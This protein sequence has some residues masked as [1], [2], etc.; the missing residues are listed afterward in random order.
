MFSIV[1]AAMGA[2]INGF[3]LKRA[4]ATDVLDAITSVL[5]WATAT[6]SNLVWDKSPEDVRTMNE[7]K[8]AAMGVG[9]DT[10]RA[11]V[12]NRWLTPTVSVPFAEHL[13]RTFSNSG[14][15]IIAATFR[16][17]STRSRVERYPSLR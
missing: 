7:Q 6:V 8:L 13:H 3:V 2:G 9:A 16:G 4:I 17:R 1:R 10:A 15:A 5:R 12:T 14:R 11:F